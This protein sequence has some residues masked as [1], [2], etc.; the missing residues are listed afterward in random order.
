MIM[1]KIAFRNIFRNRR[2]SLMTLLAITIGTVATLL[3]G[4]FTSDMMLSMQTS[5]VRRTGH[6]AVF[7]DGYFDYGSGNP[8]AYGIADYRNLLT[9]ITGDPVL[10][11]L[12]AVATPTQTI[13]G[14]AGNYAANTSKT[15]FGDG[16]VP[17]DRARMRQWNEYSVGDALPP[18]ALADDDPEGGVIG[19]GLGRILGFCELLTIPDCPPPR[20]GKERPPAAPAAA[21]AEEDFSQLVAQDKV[22]ARPADTSRGRPRIDLLAATAGGAPNVV[23]LYINRAE[24]QGVKEADDGRVVMPLA[25]AQRLLYGRGE[26]QVTSIVLQLHRTEDLDLAAQR[27]AALFKERGLALELRDFVQLNPLYGQASSF[28]AFIFAFIAVIIG[29]IVLFTI[30]NTMSMSVMERTNEIGTIRALGVQRWAVR[31]QFLAEGCLLG[32]MGATLGVAV[33]AL[34]VVAVNQ[35][36]LTWTPPTLA[37]K[38]PLHLFLFGSPALLGGTWLFLVLVATLAASAPANRAARMPVVDALRHS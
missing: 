7:H 6:L 22:A 4:A 27:L 14:I 35:A 34:V 25:L 24:F 29:M 13:F 2:R 12:I 20:A 11:P 26:H 16:I 8:A 5:T 28:F 17:S 21:A 30:V 32:V 19:L 10:K 31:K 38:I 9:L 1:L 15:F 23:T 37:G 18:I 33:T 3:F 36:G